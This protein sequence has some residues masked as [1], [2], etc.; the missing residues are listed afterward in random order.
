MN[1]SKFKAIISRKRSVSSLIS[2]TLMNRI[3]SYMNL[4]SKH[5]T[6][7]IKERNILIEQTYTN[8]EKKCL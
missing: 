2:V 1:Y 3:Y 8:T 7:I 4:L 6:K 5:V